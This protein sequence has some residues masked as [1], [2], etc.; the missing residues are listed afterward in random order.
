MLRCPSALKFG[1]IKNPGGTDNKAVFALAKQDKAILDDTVL[2]DIVLEDTILD[3]NM[4]V[5]IKYLTFC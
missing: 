4:L 1:E 2:N 3:D 5:E